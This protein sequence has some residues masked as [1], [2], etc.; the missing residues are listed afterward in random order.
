MF[1]YSHIPYSQSIYLVHI[2]P[3]GTF[4]HWSAQANETLAFV[5]HHNENVIKIASEK[6]KQTA[7]AHLIGTHFVNF[8][9]LKATFASSFD[10]TLEGEFSYC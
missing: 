9:L 1:Q 5:H 2:L 8:T 6:P 3:L 10:V 4:K 7:N